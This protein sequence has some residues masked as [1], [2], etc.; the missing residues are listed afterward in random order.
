MDSSGGGAPLSACG[1]YCETELA[2]DDFYGSVGEC[3]DDCDA[4]RVDAGDCGPA[5]DEL[6]LCLGSLTCPDSFEFW[7]ALEAIDMGEDP[8]VFPCLDQVLDYGLCLES[9]PRGGP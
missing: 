6:N 4:A 8:G 9:D 1:T 5:F 7:S 3:V 2:C